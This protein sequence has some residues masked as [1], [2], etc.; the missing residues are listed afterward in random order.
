MALPGSVLG[1][2]PWRLVLVSPPWEE[3]VE[4]RGSDPSSCSSLS[5]SNPTL[6]GPGGEQRSGVVG[7]WPPVA[8]EYQASPLSQWALPH[9]GCPIPSEAPTCSSFLHAGA[10]R[11]GGVH[12]CVQDMQGLPLFPASRTEASPVAI[13]PVLVDPQ[14]LALAPWL[15]FWDRPCGSPS[16][17]FEFDRP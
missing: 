15:L 1:S 17:L 6:Q 10:S 2:F 14:M 8:R 9:R 11:G 13:S 16:T 7:D 12:V 4:P 5:T 3:M